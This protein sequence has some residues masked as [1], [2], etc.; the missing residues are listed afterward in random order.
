MLERVYILLCCCVGGAGWMLYSINANFVM[1][2]R[3]V[4]YCEFRHSCVPGS[5]VFVRDHF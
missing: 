2:D 3:R 4:V 5:C 1:V